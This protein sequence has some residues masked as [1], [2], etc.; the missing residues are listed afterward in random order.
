M[1]SKC[2]Q[3]LLCLS[4]IAENRCVSVAEVSINWALAQRGVTSALMGAVTAEKAKQNTKSADWELS[5]DELATIEAE[6]KRI[7]R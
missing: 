5:A 6:Y 3:L 1:L 4:N 7:M 2:R